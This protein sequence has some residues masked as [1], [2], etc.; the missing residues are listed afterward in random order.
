MSPGPG[1]QGRPVQSHAP[2]PASGCAADGRR[3]RVNK[4]AIFTGL[5]V[6]MA[7]RQP[8]VTNENLQEPYGGL[9]PATRALRPSGAR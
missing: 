8:L 5:H 9:V 3:S 1:R 7:D 2:Q 4:E 6:D